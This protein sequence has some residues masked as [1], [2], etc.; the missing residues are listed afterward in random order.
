[1]RKKWILIGVGA[2]VLIGAIASAGGSGKDKSADVAITT[3]A[4]AAVTATVAPTAAPTATPKPTAKPTATPK[5]TTAPTEAPVQTLGPVQT[6]APA[7][8]RSAPAADPT[9]SAAQERDYVINTNTGK[10]HYPSCSSVK[11]I[12]PGNRQDVHMTR[13]AVIAQGWQPCGKCKP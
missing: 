12:K 9:P 10:F 7:P 1:M 4:P 8:D 3:E 2:F 13:D 6:D 5:P 11:D